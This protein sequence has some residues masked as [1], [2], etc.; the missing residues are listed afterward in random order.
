[1]IYCIV[2]CRAIV[3]SVG[4]SQQWQTFEMIRNVY[5]KVHAVNLQ[6][7]R[8]DDAIK[9]NDVYAGVRSWLY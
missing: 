8:F 9:N 1:M 6:A 2:L 5:R 4:D 7:P 3:P